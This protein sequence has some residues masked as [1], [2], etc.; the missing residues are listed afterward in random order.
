MNILNRKMD[1][2][3][4]LTIGDQHFQPSNI[5]EVNEFLLKLKEL[6]DKEKFD[7]IVSGGDLLHTHEKLHTIALNKAL[8]YIKLLTSYSKTYILVGNHDMIDCTQSLNENH[9]LNVLKE[10]RN[11]VV[12]DKIVVDNIKGKVF[13]FCPYVPDGTLLKCLNGIKVSN[14]ADWKDSSM[15]FCHQL[16]DG[17]KMGAIKVKNVEKWKETYPYICCF[18]VHEKQQPQKNMFYPGTPFQHSFGEGNKTVTIFNVN[19]EINRREVDLDLPKKVT[20]KIDIENVDKWIPLSQ[21]TRLTVAGNS[22][23]FKVFQKS[24]KFKELSKMGVKVIF[25]KEEE[26]KEI[27]FDINSTFNDTMSE[28]LKTETDKVR[29]L[30][31]TLTKTYIDNKVDILFDD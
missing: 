15:I 17:V 5:E 27:K 10:Y 20:V 19:K 28:I 29:D 4:I 23:E 9:W 14:D 30:Y 21:K 7:F 2:L 18:H 13:T 31:K 25:R 8:E 1:I 22:D 6:L 16:L 12:V 11:L 24:S 26:R 3:N